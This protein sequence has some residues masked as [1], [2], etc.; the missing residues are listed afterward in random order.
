MNMMKITNVLVGGLLLLCVA[1]NS[2]QKETPNGLKFTVVKAGDGTTAKTD[3]I[4]VFD[5]TIED[6]KDSI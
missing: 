3:Q 1:C 2:S 5:Y 6:S 4:L